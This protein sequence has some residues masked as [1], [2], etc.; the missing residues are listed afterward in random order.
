MRETYKEILQ[1]PTRQSEYVN[2]HDA[3]KKNLFTMEELAEMR[4]TNSSQTNNTILPKKSYMYRDLDS[5][6]TY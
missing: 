6:N 4:E 5:K 3:P 1:E 2:I